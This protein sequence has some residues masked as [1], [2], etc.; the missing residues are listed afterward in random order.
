MSERSYNW[1]MRNAT[2]YSDICACCMP[3][4]KCILKI[5][6]RSLLWSDE[7]NEAHERAL[8]NKK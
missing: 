8:W 3:H 4:W 5:I 6:W 1:I 7:Y 2:N